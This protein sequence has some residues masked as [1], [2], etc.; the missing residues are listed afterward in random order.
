MEESRKLRV[1][2]LY[3]VVG[4]AYWRRAIA[5]QKNAPPDFEVDIASTPDAT[6][7]PSILRKYDLVFL[8][9]YMCRRFDRY[10]NR[11]RSSAK[12]VISHNRD[13]KSRLE[14]FRDSYRPV[15][16]SGGYL[17]CNNLEVWN[18][19]GR[20]ANT[21]NI[22]NGWDA[23]VW[24]VDVPIMDRPKQVFWTGSGNPKKGKGYDD[25]LK[26]MEGP[27]CEKGFQPIF[28]AF[29]TG[30]KLSEWAWDTATMRKVYNNSFAVICASE[31]EGTPNISL[32]GMASGCV[33]VTTRV[34]NALEF[35]DGG[36]NL[37]FSDRD[38]WCMI[39]AIESAWE[40]RERLSAEATRTMF[41]W[42]YDGPDGR[43]QWFYALFRKLIAGDVP[44]PFSYKEKHWSEI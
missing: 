34:G 33:L 29:P 14:N 35:G 36:S 18:T 8:L 21:C 41:M 9:D 2:I 17:I 11:V 1:L 44:P 20:L 12:L 7:N 30:G 40:D 10:I 4:W 39:E 42:R 32:E 13:S 23:D 3:D 6:N 22:S 31:H 24:G 19:Q 27:L 38:P 26:P 5:L 16:D 43:A 37:I 25:I 28:R 15:R